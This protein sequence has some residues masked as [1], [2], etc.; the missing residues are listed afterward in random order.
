MT[1]TD[2]EVRR[3]IDSTPNAHPILVRHV[4]PQGGFQACTTQF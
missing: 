4:V 3:L 2:T 1:P